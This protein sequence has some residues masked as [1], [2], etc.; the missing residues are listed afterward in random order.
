MNKYEINNQSREERSQERDFQHLY[1]Q[2]REI[3]LN[4]QDYSWGDS[5]RKIEKYSQLTKLSQTEIILNIMEKFNSDEGALPGQLEDEYIN[6]FYSPERL[7]ENLDQREN[8]YDIINQWQGEIKGK[9]IIL[10]NEKVG[11]RINW[12]KDNFDQSIAA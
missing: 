1:R 6:L 8:F 5:R 2:V 11:Q 10:N 4:N 9:G 12:L 3:I 7:K